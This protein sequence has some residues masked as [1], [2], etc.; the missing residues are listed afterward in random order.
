[1]SRSSYRILADENQE[2]QAARYLHKRG[3]DVELVV[4]V[5]G[6]GTDDEAIARYARED[7]RIVLTADTDF[8][9]ENCPLLF[10]VDDRMSAFRI[11][12]VVDAIAVRFT[13][14]QVDRL[15]PIKVVDD[16]V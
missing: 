14:E 3:H 11:A 4:D 1:M 10:Q 13:Q 15:G 8:F 5:L 2:R 12:E 7:D 16:W 6:P 9:S